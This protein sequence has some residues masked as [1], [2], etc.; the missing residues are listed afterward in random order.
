MRTAGVAVAAAG[1]A[2]VIAGSVLGLVANGKYDSAK[3]QC[4][5]GAR[6]CPSGAVADS[7]AA[8]GL[9]TGAT[10]AFVAGAVALAG[11]AALV[12]L[13]PAP[14]APRLAVGPGS[15]GVSGRW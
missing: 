12:V 11:G 6:G 5:D 3:S 13:A 14:E 7:D 9:A 1:G 8:Y 15:I 2:A 10:I 4:K